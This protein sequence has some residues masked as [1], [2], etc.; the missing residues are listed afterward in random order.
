M[1]SPPDR[2]VISFE[3]LRRKE[4]DVSKVSVYQYRIKADNLKKWTFCI[5]PPV[6]PTKKAYSYIL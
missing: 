2:R 4:Y 1:N 5:N 3:R 6:A